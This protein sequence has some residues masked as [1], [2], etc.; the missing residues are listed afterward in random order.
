MMANYKAWSFEIVFYLFSDLGL[1]ASGGNG[2]KK[3]VYLP[4]RGAMVE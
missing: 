3:H 2:T 1:M 4:K